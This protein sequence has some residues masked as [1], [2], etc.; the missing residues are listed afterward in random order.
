MLMDINTWSLII[1]V[2]SLIVGVISIVI[3]VVAMIVSK[4][5]SDRS[6]QNYLETKKLLDEIKKVAIDNQKSIGDAIEDLEGI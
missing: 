1:G 4:K 3:A 5:E 2:A 6:V